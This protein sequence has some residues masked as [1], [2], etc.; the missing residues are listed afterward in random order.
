MKKIFYLFVV[1]IPL[2]FF[3]CSSDDGDYFSTYNLELPKSTEK[4][5]LIAPVL[6]I[7]KGEGFKDSDAFFFTNKNDETGEAVTGQ[8]EVQKVT[9]EYVMIMTPVVYG[10]Q[11]V[12]MRRGSDVY[13]LGTIYFSEN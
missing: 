1:L 13:K 5:P 10:R 8:G 9:N 6:I 2:L 12:T 7:I 3:S 11:T 4:N